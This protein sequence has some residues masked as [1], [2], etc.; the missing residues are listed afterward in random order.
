MCFCRN[1]AS[2][3]R[4]SWCVAGFRTTPIPNKDP[5]GYLKV[6]SASAYYICPARFECTKSRSVVQEACRLRR[7]LLC[8]LQALRALALAERA[9]L[10][11]PVSIAQFR[12]RPARVHMLSS[13]CSVW[14]YHIS[15]LNT[16][17]ALQLTYGSE[18]QDEPS[19]GGQHGV[20]NLLQ[21]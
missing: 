7:M 15:R 18:C 4:F 2:G 14:L 1:W 12:Y 6:A 9:H 3:A 17:V 19:R 11:V 21:V 16:R 8:A 13:K 5:V 10:F 20:H